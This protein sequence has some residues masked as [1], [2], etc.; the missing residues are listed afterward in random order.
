MNSLSNVPPLLS[1]TERD[2]LTQSSKHM[3]DGY[4]RTIKSRLQKKVQLF[5]RE[6]LPIL[7]QNGYVVTEFRNV[8]E[9][10]KALVAQAA[11][12]DFNSSSDNERSP[13]WDLNPRPKVFAPVPR[14]RGAANYE[15]FALPAELLGQNKPISA[16]RYLMLRAKINTTD[17]SFLM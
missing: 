17:I 10:S 11:E 16:A 15:T 8:T 6:E 1:K 2:F 5:V 12:R 13:R 14:N 7:I 9:N 4:H 3:S